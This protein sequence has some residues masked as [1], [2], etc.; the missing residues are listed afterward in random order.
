MQKISCQ[1]IVLGLRDYGE[2]D[3]IVSLFS[4]H[5]GKLQAIAKSA[6]KSKRRFVN[7]LEIFTLLSAVLRPSRAGLPLVE[8]AELIN[9]FLE[10]RHNAAL[11]A[12]ASLIREFLLAA[13]HEGNGDPD[14]FLLSLWVLD[15]LDRSLPQS[16]SQGSLQTGP[17]VPAQSRSLSCRAITAQFLTRYYDRI[18]YRPE[19]EH[20]QKCGKTLTTGPPWL[21]GVARG[22]IV[23]PSCASSGSPNQGP[24]QGP[25]QPIQPGTAKFLSS[26]LNAPL[27]HLNR[28]K[29]AAAPLNE[30]LRLLQAYGD[31][32][33]GREIISWRL[34][35]QLTD[36]L[37]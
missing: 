32:V 36:A 30:A 8:E 22:G 24:G 31:T 34:F 25:S 21:F 3:L 5:T 2:A 7:K 13:T 1:A 29:I 35:W 20:C 11:Y 23:C 14:M 28:L 17:T 26:C 12:A 18:G 33:L 37:G 19:L 4:P 16:L 15:S 27:N 10:L 6:R 9:S